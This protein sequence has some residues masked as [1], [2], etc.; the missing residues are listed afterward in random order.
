[1]CVGLEIN[2]G[3]SDY[4]IMEGSPDRPRILFQFRR[5][6][7]PFTVTLHPVSITE[8]LDPAGFSASDF[9]SA[10]DISEATPGKGA[11][12]CVVAVENQFLVTSIVACV[13]LL[14]G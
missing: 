9:I 7:N 6:Q 12:G 4:S 11:V 10:E 3:E 13:V 2:F 8:A 1:M 5:T 14:D